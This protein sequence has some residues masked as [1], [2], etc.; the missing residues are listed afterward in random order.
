MPRSSLASFGS[1]STRHWVKFDTLTLLGL[2][3]YQRDRFMRPRE[4]MNFQRSE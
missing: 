3:T 4:C 2:I 1:D